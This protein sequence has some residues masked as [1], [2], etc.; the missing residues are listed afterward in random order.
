[1]VF[2]RMLSNCGHEKI[3]FRLSGIERPALAELSI[4]FQKA[5]LFTQI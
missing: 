4:A 2:F 5:P 3:G 1:M